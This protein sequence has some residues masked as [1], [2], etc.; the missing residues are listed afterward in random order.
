MKNLVLSAM[1]LAMLSACGKSS[2]ISDP[3]FEDGATTE[4]PSPQPTYTPPP[5]LAITPTPEHPPHL[6]PMQ[7]IDDAI[8]EEI[9]NDFINFTPEK[10]SD[11]FKDVMLGNTDIHVD[12]YDAERDT[13]SKHS[14]T[15]HDYYNKRFE[16][17]PDF[18]LCLWFSVVDMDG[19]GIP[20]LIVGTPAAA[21]MMILRY[22]DDIVYGYG[23]F[24][25]REVGFIKTDGTFTWSGSAFDN[26]VAKMRFTESGFETITIA[27]SDYRRDEEKIYYFIDDKEVTEGRWRNFMDVHDNKEFA[28]LHYLYERPE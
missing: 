3:S 8:K 28:A 24:G 4:T 6:F 2:P 21:T 22:S 5:A 18:T 25:S 1:I 12:T 26:G 19:D 27:Y 20:E 16:N 14:I 7:E 15:L 9:I 23:T 10:V 11:I 13:W 17:E